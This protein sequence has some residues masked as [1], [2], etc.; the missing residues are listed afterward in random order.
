MILI[1]YLLVLKKYVYIVKSH[2]GI[3]QKVREYAIPQDFR[4]VP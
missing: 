4:M 2:M 3:E 1:D